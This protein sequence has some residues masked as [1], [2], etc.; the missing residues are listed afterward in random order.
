VRRTFFATPALIAIAAVCSAAEVGGNLLRRREARRWQDR[1]DLARREAG[2][3]DRLA[4]RLEHEVGGG[5]FGSSYVVRLPDADD[6]CSI[7]EAHVVS[8]LMNWRAA[9][10]RCWS[11]AEPERRTRPGKRPLYFVPS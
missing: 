8:P 2:V 9:A 6:R 5:S 10:N 7:F 3:G 11:Q 4:R 1:V